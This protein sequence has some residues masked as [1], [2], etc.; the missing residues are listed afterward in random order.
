MAGN[1]K[2]DTIIISLS[3]AAV[4]IIAIAVIAMLIYKLA[5]NSPDMITIVAWTVGVLLALQI[6]IIT[7]LFQ[8]KGSVSKL[9]EFKDNAMTDLRNLNN[10][11]FPRKR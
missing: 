7:L 5:G 10:K 2:L 9:E 11:V 8:L 4:S 1:S 6:L 3:V